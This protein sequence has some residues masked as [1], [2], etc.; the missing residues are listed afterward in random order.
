MFAAFCE[1]NPGSLQIRISQETHTSRFGKTIE[2]ECRERLAKH[3]CFI[4]LYALSLETLSSCFARFI[5]RQR[6]EQIN[7]LGGHS[8]FKV[9]DLAC[10]F[11]DCLETTMI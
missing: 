5:H 8:R 2:S 4:G 1:N 10:I 6:Q 3:A 7:H 9:V 11:V